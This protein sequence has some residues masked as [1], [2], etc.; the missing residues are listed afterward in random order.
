M[1]VDIARSHVET[2]ASVPSDVRTGMDLA[3]AVADEVI[4]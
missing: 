3:Q 1:A 2:G 4:A